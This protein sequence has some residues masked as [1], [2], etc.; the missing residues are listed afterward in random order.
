MSRL[1]LGEH[2]RE[3]IR[4]ILDGLE[5][6][7]PL[8]LVLGPEESPVSVIG[9]AGEIDFGAET[10][11]LLEQVAGLSERVS[12]TVTEVEERGRW[13]RTT[14]AGRLAYH[15]LPWGYE[16]T[17]LIGGIAEAGKAST[18]LSQ[19]SVDAL[20]SLERTVALDVYVTPT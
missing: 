19:E 9:G 1:A 16:L 15:G 2:E 5:R 14:I 8:E 6:D 17:T 4:G 11:T 18:S 3:A 10:R 20:A 7:V 13:P 12:L